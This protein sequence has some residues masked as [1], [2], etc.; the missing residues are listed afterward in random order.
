MAHGVGG[1]KDSGLAAVRGGL[2]EAGLD[3]LAFDYR[4]FGSS[5]GEPRQR[6]S[7]ADQV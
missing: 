3:V 4:S 6:V 5:K 7:V 2:A 1:T